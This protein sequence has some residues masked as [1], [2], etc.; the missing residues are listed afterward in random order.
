MFT[1]EQM[2][3]FR[4]LFDENNKIIRNDLQKDFANLRNEIRNEIRIALDETR[5]DITNTLS[6]LMNTGF[7]LHEVRINRLEKHLDLPPVK[8]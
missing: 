6:D 7:N 3:Q 8:Q 4:K 2:N 1:E 5:D